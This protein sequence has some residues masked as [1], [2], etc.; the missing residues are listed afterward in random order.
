MLSLDIAKLSIHPF[1]A[2]QIADLYWDKTFTK[3]SAKYSYYA[4]IVSLE[5]VMELPENTRIN[6]HAIKLIDGK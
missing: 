1:W 3:I 2:A 5:L 4:D 6:E